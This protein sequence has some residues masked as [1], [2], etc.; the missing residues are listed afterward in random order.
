MTMGNTEFN[1]I[2]L[3][4]FAVAMIAC[5]IIPFLFRKSFKDE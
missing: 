1:W 5:I 3:V 4:G 2:F